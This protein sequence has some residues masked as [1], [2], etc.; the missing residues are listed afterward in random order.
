MVILM[1][2]DKPLLFE[3]YVELEDKIPWCSIGTLS[4]PVE[5]MAKFEEYLSYDNM[6]IKR[7]DMSG[8]KYGGN[9]IRKL[10]FV[11]ADALNKDKKQIMTFGGLGSNHALA[12]AIYARELGMGAILVL[13]DQPLTEH[14]QEQLLRYDYFGAKLSYAKNT[15]GAVLKGLWHLITKRPYFLWIGGSSPL[16]TLGFV[17]AGLELAQQV[18]HGLLP[19][20]EHVFVAT[21]SMGTVAGLKVGFALTGLDTD[22]ICVR[23]TEKSMTDEK[24]TAKLCNKTLDLLRSHSKEIPEL[25]IKPEDIHMVHEFAGPCYGSVTEEGLEAVRIIGE[26]EGIKLET[27]Y[28]A[29]AFACMI[30]YIKNGKV[31]GPILF[32]NTYNSV[33]LTQI[34]SDHHDFSLLPKSFHKFFRENLISYI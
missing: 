14:V 4:T 9:K 34:V 15:V 21:G 28:T 32:W 24:K 31:T 26:T 19:K 6:W 22:L 1:T 11:L 5:R 10:E 13:I 18:E 27:T 29:K 16:G 23:V 3:H 20:P 2:R 8:D 33:D 17:D 30:D 25:Q 7:D 12:T